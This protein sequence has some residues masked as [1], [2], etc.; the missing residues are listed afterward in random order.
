MILAP[1]RP[2]LA[3]CARRRWLPALTGMLM[4]ATGCG[5]GQAISLDG[6]LA[7]GSGDSV[8]TRAAAV[9][10]VV[11]LGGGEVSRQYDRYQPL[12]VHLRQRL[13]CAVKMV[14]V[15]DSRRISEMFGRGEAQFAALNMT[16]RLRLAPDSAVTIAVAQPL[17]AARALLVVR[18]GSL[19][20]DFA[21]LRGKSIALAAAGHSDATAFVA[22]RTQRAGRLPET[23]FT[24]I[25]QVTDFGDCVRMVTEGKSD[26]ACVSS[27]FLPEIPDTLKVIAASEELVGD[28]IVANQRVPPALRTAMIDALATLPGTAAGE[29]CLAALACARFTTAGPEAAPAW[30]A[31]RETAAAAAAD[32]RAGG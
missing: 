32:G 18:R 22:R 31:A 10:F 20:R 1:A 4:L 29:R 23:Y 28:I 16:A 30:R 21:D 13:G 5:G 8:P 24:A 7:P 27:A 15:R 19:L 11:A 14:Y 2:R 6:E 9:R 25:R 17:R 26:A 3:G 12:A